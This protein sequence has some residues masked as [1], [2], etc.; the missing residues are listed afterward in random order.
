M[1]EIK[2]IHNLGKY[3]VVVGILEIFIFQL[4]TYEF[5]FFLMIIGLI[6]IILA[7]IALQDDKIKFNYFIGCWSLLKYNPIGIS[8]FIFVLRGSGFK[9]DL[10]NII[11]ISWLLI[12]LSSFVCGIIIIIKTSKYLKNKINKDF[13]D[14]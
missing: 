8:M 12:A 6:T 11:I 7:Y 14:C 3:F 1:K 9:S 2:T 5:D 10:S 4:L 13:E